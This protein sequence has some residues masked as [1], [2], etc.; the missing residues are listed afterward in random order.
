MKNTRRITESLRN[1]NPNNPPLTIS[2]KTAPT[3]QEKLNT[4][5]DTLEQIFAT[6]SDIDRTFTV[7]TDQVVRDFLREL[8]TDRM[9]A[10]NR[11]EVA[12]IVRRFTPRKAAGPGGIQNICRRQFSN[13]F[14]K[15]FI[16]HLC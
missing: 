14:S 9:R 5:T 3:T 6:N 15:Y 4:L 7:S 1:I 13:L 16:D 12:W 11:S 2:G 8:L 10:T